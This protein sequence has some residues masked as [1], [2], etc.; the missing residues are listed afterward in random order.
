MTAQGGKQFNDATTPQTYRAQSGNEPPNPFTHPSDGHAGTTAS[1]A[2]AEQEKKRL[3][4]LYNPKPNAGSA[5]GAG[6]S[7]GSA[8]ASARSIPSRA[9]AL[10]DFHGT[11]QGDL[12]FQAGDTIQITGEE[13]EMWWRGTLDGRTGIFPSN[14]VH[15]L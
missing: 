12:S 3:E 5:T 11:E 14:Y 2:S 8:G 9:K 13:D 6:A 7:A 4:Q 10:Y 15:G 1:F